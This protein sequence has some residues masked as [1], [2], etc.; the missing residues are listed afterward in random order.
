MREWVQSCGTRNVG[1]VR[2]LVQYFSYD[3]RLGGSEA[4]R[5]ITMVVVKEERQ[6]CS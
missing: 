2:K 5:T 1:S 3:L 4:R 6:S